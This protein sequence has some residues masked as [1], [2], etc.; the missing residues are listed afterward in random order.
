MADTS[1]GMGGGYTHD[2]NCYR[3]GGSC[4][5]GGGVCGK[6]VRATPPSPSTAPEVDVRHEF[7]RWMSQRGESAVYI[8]DGLY[9]TGAVCDQAE[10]FAAGV[11]VAR[12]A[13]ASRPAEP[14]LKHVHERENAESSKRA[15]VD[16]EALPPLPDSLGLGMI[17]GQEVPAYTAEQFRQGQRDAVATDRARR[18]V[19]GGVQ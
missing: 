9:S 16:D 8:G 14:S 7:E 11:A 4:A 6:E 17:D 10:A 15:E 5:C 18:A 2:R 1:K 3:R 19:A 13:L 12:A